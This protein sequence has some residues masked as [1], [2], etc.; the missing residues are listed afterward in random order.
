MLLC[1]TPVDC[2]VSL[3]ISIFYH[4]LATRKNTLKSKWGFVCMLRQ[5]VYEKV[6][7]Q[8]AGHPW[9]FQFINL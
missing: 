6:T 4:L 3:F 9:V 8:L 1:V 2:Q 7:S 5:N